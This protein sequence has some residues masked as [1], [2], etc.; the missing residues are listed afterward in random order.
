M[1]GPSGVRE[2]SDA[3]LL[4]RFARS[5]DPDAFA[6]LVTRHGP[7]V[8]GV[9]RRLLIDA[10]DAEDAFQA[11]FLVL[12]RKAGAIGDRDL[13]APWLYGVARRTA[14]K[15]RCRAARR[16][17]HEEPLVDLPLA[18]PE[19][20]DAADLRRVLDEEV[21]R[22]PARY[23]A[24]FILCYLEGK[25]NEEAARTLGCPRGTV[26]SR[27]AWARQRLRG[28]LTHRGL[29][30]STGLLASAL[31][32]EASAVCARLSGATVLAAQQYAMK[33]LSG[34]TISASVAVLTRGVLHAMFLSRLSM[35]AGLSLVLLLTGVAAGFLITTPPPAAPPVEQRSD[36]TPPASPKQKGPA[37]TQERQTAQEV[38]SK[39]FQT[40]AR[41]SLH[42]E[43]FN[44][45]IT[46][47]RASERTVNVKVTKQT[48]AP[49]ADAAKKALGEI[50]VKMD[51][52]G[53]KVRVEVRG[54]KEHKPETNLGASA[55]VQ[56]PP[57]ANLD[58]HTS[59]GPVTLTGGTGNGVVWTSNGPI[60]V[61]GSR[62]RLD[63]R[64]SNGGVEVEAEQVQAKI[65]TSN[66]NVQFRGSLAE[67]T[68]TFHTSTGN[69]VLTLPASTA[70]RVDAQTSNGRVTCNFPMHHLVG[71]GSLTVGRET[72]ER[73]GAKEEPKRRRNRSSTSSLH[74]SIGEGS[75]LT[76]TLSTSNG[77]ITI[78]QATK[79]E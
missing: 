51:Q 2:A 52:D 41:P 70:G 50:D 67:G 15:A 69:L 10:H 8:L 47:T 22:L 33:G 21:S 18:S 71:A 63:L 57:G 12:V 28:R 4:G 30:L 1:T 14:A 37:T 25:S 78:R 66:G 61:K 65:T 73:S 45:A 17:L 3:E 64:T 11:T 34:G 60:T 77:N 76:L 74:G 54:P 59:N 24:P 43:V 26:K 31:A 58:L 36:A 49:D 16:R 27:L 44:G 39:T 7:M 42:L 23:R 6:A 13:L 53:D 38:V 79:G 48:R 68:H 5:R 19:T 9:C 75:A 46:V 40:G 55:E 35:T 62:G 56:L 72:P 20:P 29:V 32:G